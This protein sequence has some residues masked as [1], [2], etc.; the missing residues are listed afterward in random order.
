M[1]QP[2]QEVTMFCSSLIPSLL[3]VFTFFDTSKV[4]TD[5]PLF[6]ILEKNSENTLHKKKVKDYIL[7]HNFQ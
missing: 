4:R 6:S 1:C 7:L 5:S 3:G 2:L